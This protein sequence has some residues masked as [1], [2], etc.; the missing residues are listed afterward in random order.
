M[1]RWLNSGQIDFETRGSLLSH[2]G[3]HFLLKLNY[4][5]SCNALVEGAWNPVW[6]CQSLATRKAGLG[7]EPT[8]FFWWSKRQKYLVCR[9]KPKD[10]NNHNEGKWNN[11]INN[12]DCW[13]RENEI[14]L[15]VAYNNIWVIKTPKLKVKGRKKKK[16]NHN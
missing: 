4:I 9:N 1:D 16:A 2:W 3:V 11:V 13:I 8:S 7:A 15:L 12:R 6:C 14:Q 5:R 10:T